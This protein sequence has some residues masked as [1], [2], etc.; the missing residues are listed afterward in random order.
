MKLD[1]DS[2]PCA[3]PRGAW[4]VSCLSDVSQYFLSAGL[5]GRSLIGLVGEDQGD[6]GGLKTWRLKGIKVT[7][8]LATQH[9]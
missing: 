8:S 6:S 3:P 2:A 1:E 5:P 9:K 7:P 4:P